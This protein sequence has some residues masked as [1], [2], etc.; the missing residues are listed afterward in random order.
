MRQVVDA[1]FTFL[2]H[3]GQPIRLGGAARSAKL[4]KT[5]AAGI[6]PQMAIRDGADPV[7]YA[8]ADPTADVSPGQRPQT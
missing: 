3:P 2:S 7:A 8:H 4:N 5:M 1:V 6:L